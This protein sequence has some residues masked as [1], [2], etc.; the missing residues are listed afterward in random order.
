MTFR[1]A[2]ASDQKTF[3]G[4]SEFEESITYTRKKPT[5]G[6]TEIKTIK[7]VVERPLVMPTNHAGMRFP[8]NVY[9]VWIANDATLGITSVKIGQDIVELTTISGATIEMRIT[10]I[11]DQD[12][13]MWHLE[14]QA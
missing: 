2:I 7:A 14:A 10:K 1:D 8:Q 9:D 4:N 3:L 6:E 13:G 5:T 11:I 12:A